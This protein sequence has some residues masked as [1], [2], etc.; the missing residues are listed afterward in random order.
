M[1]R[2]LLDCDG[3]VADFIGGVCAGLKARGFER[4]PEDVKHWALEH[5][6]TEE[7]TRATYELM[8]EPGFCH[9]LEWYEGARDFLRD[10][11]R[12]GEVHVV[13][14]PFRDG[15]S[16]MNERLAWLSSE[17]P[18]AAGDR[19]H[20]IQGKHKH[21]VRGDV[22]IEDH[23]MTAHDWLVANPDGIAI[24]IDRPWNRPGAAEWHA[25]ARMYRVRS[26]DEALRV[27]R[28]CA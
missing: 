12:E 21:I 22:L 3:V 20:F 17:M 24:L 6:F 7:E 14:A 28:E 25:H 5:S 11:L 27:V 1:K 4:T 8:K 26:F 23:P 9:E 18:G 2:I 16:W 19:V 13:T 10:L 15:T